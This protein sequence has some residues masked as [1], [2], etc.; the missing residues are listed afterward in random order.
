[1]TQRELKAKGI[2]KTDFQRFL[3]DMDFPESIKPTGKSYKEG[4]T[5]YGQWL[6]RTDPIQFN[7][8]YG[9]WVAERG[10]RNGTA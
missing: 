1:M 5:K 6:R 2:T 4:K 10:Y 9:E 8:A 3:D 7:V